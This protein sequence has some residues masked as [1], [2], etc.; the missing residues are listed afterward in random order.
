MH[1]H[2]K[3]SLI[4]GANFIRLMIRLQ[5]NNFLA[6]DAHFSRPPCLQTTYT[7]PGR[8]TILKH[9]IVN[10]PLADLRKIG[11]FPKEFRQTSS[12]FVLCRVRVACMTPR[13]RC[14]CGPCADV[15]SRFLNCM[16]IT[17]DTSTILAIEAT[18]DLEEEAVTGV[19]LQL[20]F[21][22]L[23]SEP[24]LRSNR[25]RVIHRP[26]HQTQDRSHPYCEPVS[27][28]LMLC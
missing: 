4:L 24:G 2:Q 19:C 20:E 9:P 15:L 18:R 16:R 28:R 3:T 13:T 11:T 23:C 27:G 22:V 7:T 14:G 17:H 5:P 10:S 12:P 1:L 26:N 8:V 21:I 6:P 25:H